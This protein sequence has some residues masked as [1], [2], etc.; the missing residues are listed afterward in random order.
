[1]L[2][3]LAAAALN[4]GDCSCSC[5]RIPMAVWHHQPTGH[6]AY[7]QLLPVFHCHLH[8]P[9]PRLCAATP[10][11][12]ADAYLDG[13]AAR[14]ACSPRAS[15]RGGSRLKTASNVTCLSSVTAMIGTKQNNNQYYGNNFRVIP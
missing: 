4:H 9:V 15:P 8:F 11:E 5:H 7:D 13:L 14:A 6:D 2:D 12:P 10:F 1:M 3:R